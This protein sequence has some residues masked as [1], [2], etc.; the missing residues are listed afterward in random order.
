MMKA[1][2]SLLILLLLSGVLPLNVNAQNDLS[3]TQPCYRLNGKYIGSYFGDSWEIIKS[4]VSWE[5]NDWLKAGIFAGSW[6]A[7]YTQDKPIQ[8]FFQRNRS[9]LSSNASK[10]FFDPLGYGLY[11]L[12]VFGGLYL[13]GAFADQPET[14]H[15]ALTGVKVFVISGVFAEA[16]KH[17]SHRHRPYQD[18][19]PDPGNWDGPF[20][21]LKYDAFPSGHTIT[22]FAS[23][24]FFTNYFPEKK[25]VGWLSYSLATGVGLSRLN[26]NKHW[27]TDVLAGAVLG[28]YIGKFLSGGPCREKA[29]D[30][31]V[32]ANNYGG[33]SLIYR[34]N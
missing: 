6:F 14:L 15:F 9:P 33:I 23:A 2:L 26:D 27:A 16:I 19:P 25:W 32:I 4:P 28:H 22:A 20:S 12:P 18:Q 24:A 17:F 1:R 31:T 21:L 29:V 11:T 7:L 8:E 10:Y 3:S 5:G 13:Y 30:L 34:I